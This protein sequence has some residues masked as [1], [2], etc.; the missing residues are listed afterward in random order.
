MSNLDSLSN[1]LVHEVAE[2]TE[3]RAR[4][5]F[6]VAYPRLWR[7]STS[8]KGQFVHKVE[9]FERKALTHTLTF[10]DILEA[11][12]SAQSNYRGKPISTQV[13]IECSRVVREEMARRAASSELTNDRG[14]PI[15][16]HKTVEAI[17]LMVHALLSAEPKTNLKEG[18]FVSVDDERRVFYQGVPDKRPIYPTNNIDDVWR[19]PA[20]QF[21]I[22]IDTTPWNQSNIQI[23]INYK[24]DHLEDG[25]YIGESNYFTRTTI[26]NPPPGLNDNVPLK[27][28]V[29]ILLNALPELTFNGEYYNR[30]NMDYDFSVW[31]VMA[32]TASSLFSNRLDIP[33]LHLRGS[34]ADLAVN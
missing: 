16:N 4:R 28:M 18:H 34:F 13:L 31:A 26:N 27:T 17:L 25:R 9:E 2:Y 11:I 7:A 20:I 15:P 32:M 1:E 23:A 12:A 19:N 22:E 33:N 30:E 24:G 29:E 21:D 3:G 5:N 10:G 8:P 6:T 14:K